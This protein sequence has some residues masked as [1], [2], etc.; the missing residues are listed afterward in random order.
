MPQEM[1][2]LE[3]L[4]A[5]DVYADEDLAKKRKR[6]KILQ[7][8]ELIFPTL[9]VCGV[10]R[11]T[12]STFYSKGLDS[13]CV[14]RAYRDFGDIRIGIGDLGV[15]TKGVLAA[16]SSKTWGRMET[17]KRVYDEG[18]EVGN[19]EDWRM[20]VDVLIALYNEGVIDLEPM[21]A[22]MKIAGRG[23]MRNNEN[24]RLEIVRPLWRDSAITRQNEIY[25]NVFLILNIILEKLDVK[26]EFN[27]LNMRIEFIPLQGE[28]NVIS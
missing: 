13:L 1:I 17:I 6:E 18:I 2:S 19:D 20:Q 11:I 25:E 3:E 15:T 12:K 23:M 16:T 9:E 7:T 26:I 27:S 28:Q 22:W 5:S 14:R 21:K 4:L 24:R 8:E 10:L